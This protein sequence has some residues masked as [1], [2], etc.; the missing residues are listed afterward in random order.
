MIRLAI[1]VA[2][3]AV[4]LVST[5]CG[6]E[7]RQSRSELRAQRAWH[8]AFHTRQRCDQKG[9]G[10]FWCGSWVDVCQLAIGDAHRYYACSRSDN[11]P[12]SITIS[13]VCVRD[14][15]ARGMRVRVSPINPPPC[16]QAINAA[17]LP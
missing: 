10:L 11:D 3:T 12:V 15:G 17:G 9:G 16:R 7:H 4:V 1:G 5:A 13:W 2:L 14:S 6:G 8:A